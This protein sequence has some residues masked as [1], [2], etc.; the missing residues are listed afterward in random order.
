MK[1]NLKK[2]RTFII[3]DIEKTP[4]RSQAEAIIK[5]CETQ[6]CFLEKNFA[7]F[8]PFKLALNQ[9]VKASDL[10]AIKNSKLIMN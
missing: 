7:G 10:K 4:G 9:P 6:E 2:N 3:Q 8:N 5:N 1:K